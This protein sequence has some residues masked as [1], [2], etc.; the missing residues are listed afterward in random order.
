MTNVRCRHKICCQKRTTSLWSLGTGKNGFQASTIRVDPATLGTND[1]H[2]YLEGSLGYPR[3]PTLP[4]N[5]IGSLRGDVRPDLCQ[6]G[7]SSIPAW[8]VWCHSG[9]FNGKQPKPDP[10][11]VQPNSCSMSGSTWI[12]VEKNIPTRERQRAHGFPS[13]GGDRM[14]S[15]SFRARNDLL[16]PIQVRFP[17][18]IVFSHV[19]EIGIVL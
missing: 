17:S 10:S 15:G 11:T 16:D 7:L 6:S 13:K 3:P 19:H 5:S 18:F 2:G 4:H 12:V 14:L 1:H 8:S 9:L